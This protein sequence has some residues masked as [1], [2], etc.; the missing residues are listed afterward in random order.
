MS[1]ISHM[2]LVEKL[3]NGTHPCYKTCVPQVKTEDRVLKKKSSE[4]VV[5]DN[6]GWH[7]LALVAECFES[8]LKYK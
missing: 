8:S 5:L 7:I 2:L 1:P 6:S 3:P 4:K